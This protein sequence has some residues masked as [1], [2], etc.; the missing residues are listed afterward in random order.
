M[1]NI[2]SICGSFILLNLIP[3]KPKKKWK[4]GYRV[5]FISVDSNSAVYI[6]KLIFPKG[7]SIKDIRFVGP[8]S[9]YLPHTWVYLRVAMSNFHKPSHLTQNSDILYGHPLNNSSCRSSNISLGTKILYEFIT[10]YVLNEFI[11]YVCMY[12]LL[13]AK[14]EERLWAK[15]RTYALKIELKFLVR[16]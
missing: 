1:W 9:T 12:I 6:A 7:L 2:I 15:V 13:N 8:L 5:S 3:L 11:K 10:E 16:L 4:R 14:F